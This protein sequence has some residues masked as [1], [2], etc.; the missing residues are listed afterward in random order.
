M[1]ADAR[2]APKH[3]SGLQIDAIDHVHVSRYQCGRTGVRVD[4][5]KHFDLIEMAD[6]GVPMAFVFTERGG[7]SRLPRVQPIGTATNSRLPIHLAVL[8]G[9]DDDV[10]VGQDEREVCVSAVKA[11]HDRVLIIRLYVGYRR[12][13]WLGCRGGSFTAVM[14]QGRDYVLRG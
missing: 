6:F 10:V 9:L 7:Y 3:S 13:K 8:L 11:N 1:N 5:R 14:V 4:N 12:Q 2:V